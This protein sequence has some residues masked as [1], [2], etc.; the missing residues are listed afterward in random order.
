MGKRESALRQ[1]GKRPNTDI[2]I[3]TETYIQTDR[4]TLTERKKQRNEER[5]ESK[6]TVTPDTE[7]QT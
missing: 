4:Q 7:L 6:Q 2:K 5:Q 1:T 3:Q